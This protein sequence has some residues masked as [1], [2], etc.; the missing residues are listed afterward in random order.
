MPPFERAKEMYTVYTYVRFTQFPAVLN[1]DQRSERCM[2]VLVRVPNL[3][4]FAICLEKKM[5]LL[6]DFV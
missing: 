3:E 4:T 2:N 5:C 1:W 6:C